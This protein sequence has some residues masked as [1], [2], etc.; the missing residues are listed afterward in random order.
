MS[1]EVRSNSSPAPPDTGGPRLDPVDGPKSL[2]IEFPTPDIDLADSGPAA[3]SDDLGLEAGAGEGVASGV[4]LLPSRDLAA[5]RLAAD[6]APRASERPPPPSQRLASSHPFEAVTPVPPSPQTVPN[7]VPMAPITTTLPAPAPVLQPVAL[8]AGFVPPPPAVPLVPA[9]E[10]DDEPDAWGS[11]P[12]P[13]A[14]PFVASPSASGANHVAAAGVVTEPAPP[15][16]MLSEPVPLTKT[17]GSAP[18]AKNTLRPGLVEPKRIIEVLGSNVPV[19]DSALEEDAIEDLDDNEARELAEA[20]VSDPPI[21]VPDAELD[22][23]VEVEDEGPLEPTGAD[24]AAM[25]LG[26]QARLS[27]GGQA[28]MS[29]DGQARMSLGGQARRSPDAEPPMSLDEDAVALATDP[30]PPDPELGASSSGSIDAA[31][32]AADAADAPGTGAKRV[33]APPNKRKRPPPPS[34]RSAEMR[35]VDASPPGARKWWEEMFSEEFL[36]AIPILSP[37]QLEREVN[38]I[39]EALAVDRGARILDLACGAG[40]HAVELA[41]RGYDLVGFDLSQSQ[42]DWAGGLAQERNQRL[43][44]T[45]GDM[46]ELS[47]NESFD[48]VYSWNTSFGFFE[49]EK[50]VDVAQR[51]FRALRPGGRFLLDVINRDFVVAQQP[52]QTWFEGDGCVC[53]DDVSIDFITSRMKVKRTLMLTNGKNRECNYS[54]RIYGLH[55]L[56]KMLHDV[57]FKVLNVSGRPEMP[58]VFFGST[59]PRIIILAAKP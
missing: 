33:K 47:Y 3:L 38:F 34:S 9:A 50:N 49:E 35:K 24:E 15:P 55:E 28:R 57:G 39:D 46:R 51:V 58:G 10:P 14:A 16:R 6:L 54:V 12:A 41:T 4:T 36:R 44:F 11:S 27:P 26:G 52:G 1:D 2:E 7:P 17:V 31:A 42:L 30:A 29:L 13:R 18:P 20:P 8:P 48:A 22:V 25:S 21:S 45:Y 32:E 37:K 23:Q 40:Q 43:Q 56:G 19:L 5:Q 59:S 53:I